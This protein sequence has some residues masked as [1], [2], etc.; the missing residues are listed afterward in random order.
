[1][2]RI[3][4]VIATICI[5][6]EFGLQTAFCSDAATASKE[7]VIY[8]FTGGVDGGY[9]A[10]DLTLDSAGNL[11]GTTGGGGTGTG[12][13]GGCG[14]VYELKHTSDGWKKKVLYSFV[15]GKDAAYPSGGLVFDKAGNLY[16]VAGGGESSI[17]TAFKLTPDSR[18]GWTEAVIFNFTFDCC[19]GPQGDLAFDASG[20]L[21]G[22]FPAGIKGSC[23]SGEGCGGVYRLTP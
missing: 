19:G 14:T 1:M 9:P 21:Y 16:G 5:L 20:N 3:C 8:S 10:S 6:A 18:G 7:K 4:F 17:G 22:I 2:R 13:N 23:I 12:C 15:G 11:Y